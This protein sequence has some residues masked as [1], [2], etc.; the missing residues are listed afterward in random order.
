[1]FGNQP[2]FA[3]TDKCLTAINIIET[4]EE[5]VYAR[6]L[7]EMAFTSVGVASLALLAHDYRLRKVIFGH[8]SDGA[9]PESFEG[10]GIIPFSGDADGANP[11]PN[12]CDHFRQ[13]V[14]DAV[15][16]RLETASPALTQFR[17]PFPPT[18]VVKCD[19]FLDNVYWN[20]YYLGCNTD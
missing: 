16:K 20:P 5:F 3:V 6:D 2:P 15:T 1:M 4:L 18:C 12:K 19:F 7:N 17:L 8:V 11:F 14:L 9:H 10:D 13:T